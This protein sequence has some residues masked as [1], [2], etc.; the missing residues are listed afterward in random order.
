MHPEV[1]FETA[2]SG[3]HLVAEIAAVLLDS[4]VCPLVCRQSALDGECSETVEAL[5]RF[6][7]RVDSQVSNHITWF[8][9]FLTA[10]DA[11]VP[12]DAVNLSQEEQG[13]YRER[14]I[15]GAK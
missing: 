4:G 3:K 12:P 6:F 15:P 13:K 2:V 8:L 1:N 7:L 10:I 11:L 5:E 9:E 14:S